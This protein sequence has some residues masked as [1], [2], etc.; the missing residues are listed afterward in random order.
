L[1]ICVLRTSRPCRLCDRHRPFSTLGWPDEGA[2]DLARF[3]PTHMMETGHDILFFWVARM[4]MMGLELTGQPPFRTVLLHGLV[5]GCSESVQ[6]PCP[7]MSLTGT[8]RPSMDVQ[9][10]CIRNSMHTSCCAHYLCNEQHVAELLLDAR[11]CM[12]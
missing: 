3:Y 7:H 10:M 11:K 4:V 12:R 9:Q 5:C 2:A 1:P 8:W 6:E